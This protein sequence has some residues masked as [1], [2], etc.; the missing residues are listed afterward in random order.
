[1]VSRQT[2]KVV[3]HEEFSR[4]PENFMEEGKVSH[5]AGML[6]AVKQFKVGRQ[7]VDK[8]HWAAVHLTEK[9]KLK[10]VVSSKRTDLTTSS[11][12][13]A[14]DELVLRSLA[15]GLRTGYVVARKACCT[16]GFDWRCR[17]SLV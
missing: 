6:Q 4:D 13:D 9:S 1:M 12:D 17:S 8:L 3:P 16:G 5:R 10:Q 7:A 14:D 2:R 15:L 11:C